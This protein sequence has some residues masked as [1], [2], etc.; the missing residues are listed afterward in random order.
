MSND[1]RGAKK[2]PPVRRLAAELEGRKTLGK[3]DVAQSVSYVHKNKEELQQFE[4]VEDFELAAY[5]D[6]PHPKIRG[7]AYHFTGIR[8]ALARELWA[9]RIF[10][11]ISVLDD[12]LFY[13]AREGDSANIVLDV[14]EQIRDSGLNRPGLV[15]FPIHSFGIFGAGILVPLRARLRY[16]N[17]RYGLALT[18]QTNSMDST[19]EFLDMV[20]DPFGIRKRIPKDLIDHWR[21]SRQTRWLE[22]NPLLAIRAISVS[23]YYDETESLL[24]GRLRTLTTFIAMLSTL[25][26]PSKERGEFL[27]SSS[28]VNNW[29]TLDIHHYIVLSDL[30]RDKKSLR[31]HCVPIHRRSGVVELS[32]LSVE[33]NPYY[34]RRRHNFEDNLYSALDNVYTGY[35]TNS[36]LSDR[37]DATS[38]TYRKLF[39]ALTYFR[40]SFHVS[41]ADWSATI[42]LSTAFEMLLTDHF[43]SGVS[44]RLVR[45]LRLLLKGTPGTR[46][47]QTAVADLYDARSQIVHAGETPSADLLTARRAFVLAFVSLTSRLHTLNNSSATPIRD[48]TGDLG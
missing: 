19:L 46:S 32:D 36:V 17:S 47:Y 28:R 3:H 37:D 34:W 8:A 18:P 7:L 40:R 38:R 26:P 27:F 15:V 35:L 10:V 12:L 41:D 5:S 1:R 4:Y 44:T 30:P 33:L 24:L 14:L 31:G 23:N 20:R 16:I 29:E 11:G 6:A 48:L 25:Q 2:L 45:R 39:E 22:R 42:S 9:R 13:A 43:A 21:R